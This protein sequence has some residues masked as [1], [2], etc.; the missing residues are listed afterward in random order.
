MDLKLSAQ[1]RPE[2]EKTPAD[3]LPAV[4]YGKGRENV[5][6]SLDLN[7]FVKIFEA[8]GESNLIE[9]T[10]DGQEAVKVLVK[11]VQQEL[12]KDRPRHVDF[13]QVNMKEK[14]KTEIPLHFIGE[15]KAV[16]ELGGIFL[17]EIDG[18][19]VECLPG[20]LVDHIDVDISSLNTFDDEIRLNDLKLPEGMRLLAETNEII[21]QV[22]EPAKQEVEEKPE[23]TPAA[24][25]SSKEGSDSVGK[26]EKKE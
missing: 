16:R 3:R 8:A 6:L 14:I 22:A 10:V 18:V 21:A 26:D 19:E 5:N 7:D 1:L 13:Y 15:S 2:G 25:T 9:L 12:I 17:R 11:E 23:E 24:E 20:D 4:L